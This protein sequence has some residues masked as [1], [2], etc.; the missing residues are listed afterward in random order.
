M[1]SADREHYFKALDSEV[2]KEL[3]E[4]VEVARLRGMGYYDSGSRSF[5]MVDTPVESPD[6]I[7][8]QKNTRDEKPDRG[9]D[10]RRVWWW[11]HTDLLG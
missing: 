1:Y 11:S 2:G 9:Q 5:Y 6:D 7:T 3:L 10:D 8:E 4:S